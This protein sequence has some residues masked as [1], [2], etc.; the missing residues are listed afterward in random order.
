M[1]KEAEKEKTMANISPSY[2]W[3]RFTQLL[4]F[5]NEEK[6]ISYQTI[7]KHAYKAAQET[8]GKVENT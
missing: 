5:C 7:A 1:L 6:C 3:P 8:R 4:S 2:M